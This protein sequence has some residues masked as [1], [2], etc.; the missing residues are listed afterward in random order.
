[1]ELELFRTYYDDGTNSEIMHDGEHL[2]NAIELP[3]KNNQ[4]EISCVPEGR[5]ELKKRCS[6]HLGWHLQVCNVPE[7]DL[8]L[9]HAANDALHELKGC[10][11]PVSLLTGEG[12]GLE[13][14]Q[15]LAKVVGL[16]YPQFKI[17]ERVFLMIGHR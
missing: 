10:I 7:R 4:H 1:M 13:S 5:Y 16:V 6:D 8:I 3:W 14:R 9:I 17:E 12:K 15:A 2:C 11:A